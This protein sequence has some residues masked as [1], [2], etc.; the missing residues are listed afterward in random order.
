MISKF[1][2][3]SIFKTLYINFKYLK[4][5]DA[6]KFPIIIYRNTIIEKAK[7]AIL[8]EC[9]I[10]PGLFLFGKHGV[11]NRLNSIWLLQDRSTLKIKGKVRMGSGTKLSVGY[12]S[13]L[14][15]GKNIKV[16]GD[17]SII[18]KKSI[19]IGHHCLL[20]WDCLIMDT[21]FHKIRPICGG[22]KLTIH[23]IS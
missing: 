3:I 11:G 7:G 14:S 22:G 1:A 6:I 12:N 4:I 19:S 16:T 9:P 10:K 17:T 13:L 23:Q 21:D 20:S 8:F 15:L 18:C 2:G 5:C